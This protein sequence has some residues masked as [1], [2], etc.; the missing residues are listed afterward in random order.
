LANTSLDTAL[1]E[2]PA[3]ESIEADVGIS[4]ERAMSGTR[5]RINIDVSQTFTST[6]E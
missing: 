6:K 1:S 3:I 4:H 2:G 5:R